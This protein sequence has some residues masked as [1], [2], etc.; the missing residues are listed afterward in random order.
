MSY[1]DEIIEDLFVSEINNASMTVF[2]KDNRTF[3]QCLQEKFPYGS[4][5]INWGKTKGY[6][7]LSSVSKKNKDILA[8]ENFFNE[9]ILDFVFLYSGDGEIDCVFKGTKDA[10]RH[11]LNDLL[12]IPQHH[13]FVALDYSWCLCFTFEGDADF[14]FSNNE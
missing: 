11:K 7:Y 3:F 12:E 14:A 13:Y 9:N 10:F 4:S 6:K 2:S 8:Y 5:K 1:Y